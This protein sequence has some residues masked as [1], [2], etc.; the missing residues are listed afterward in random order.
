MLCTVSQ[1]MKSHTVFLSLIRD[2]HALWV[3][4]KISLGLVSYTTIDFQRK[5]YV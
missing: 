1:R 5:V 3:R 4:V 2:V